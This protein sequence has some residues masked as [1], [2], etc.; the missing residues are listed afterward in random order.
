MQ[1]KFHQYHLS[2]ELAKKYSHSTYLAS[3]VNESE[4]QVVL[5]H[6]VRFVALCID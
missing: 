4:Q 3:P 1:K 2:A 5:S 6:R